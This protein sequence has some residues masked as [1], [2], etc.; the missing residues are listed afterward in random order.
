MGQ[1]FSDTKMFS[2]QNFLTKTIFCHL[3]TFS[4]V[5]FGDLVVKNLLSL[6]IICDAIVTLQIIRRQQVILFYC[7]NKMVFL[8]FF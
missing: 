1:S 5:L 4:D 6:K 8:Y 2:Y 7:S 3:E